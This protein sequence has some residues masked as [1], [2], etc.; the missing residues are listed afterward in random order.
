MPPAVNP[1]VMAALATPPH[2][3][4]SKDPEKKFFFV[5]ALHAADGPDA[6]FT[7]DVNPD[8]DKYCQLTSP[9][10]CTVTVS[11]YSSGIP[12]N[13][14]KLLIYQCLME[15]FHWNFDFFM[16]QPVRMHL[17]DVPLDLQIIEFIL[18]RNGWCLPEMPAL[19]TNILISMDDR[20]LYA[21]CW[22]HGDIR[23]YDIS[24]PVNPK[25]NSQVY[26][27]GN[28]HSESEVKVLDEDTVIPALYVKRRKIE[29]GPQMLQ[30][31][32]DGKRLYVTTSL[33]KTWDHQFYPSHSKSGATMLQHNAS[34]TVRI[35]RMR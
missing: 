29:G 24:D 1:N 19:I 8:S 33:Y 28:I 23:Q 27:G 30:L 4:P 9:K 26:I 10:D 2:K 16:S 34:S 5:T 35:W 12:K 32:L 25:L 17:L 6:I 7:V 22:L 20:F 14:S 13:T 21:S 11:I 15:L 18:M 3:M 31:S